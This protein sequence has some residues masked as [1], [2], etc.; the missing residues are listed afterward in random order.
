MRR[1]KILTVTL[2]IILIQQNNAVS[3]SALTIKNVSVINELGHV[4]ISWEYVGSDTLT[5][6]KY[7]RAALS[8]VEFHSITDPS[9]TSYIDTEANAHIEPQSYRIGDGVDITDDVATFLLTFDYDSCLQQIDLTWEDLKVDQYT[10]NDW[11]PSEFIINIYEDGNLRMETVDIENQ[12][13]SI[14]NVLE[15]T[16]Y[17]IFVETKW[18]GQD[19]TS[20]SNP[21]SK[22]TEMPESPEYINAVYATANGNSVDLKFNIAPNSEL[23]TYKLLKSSTPNGNYDTLEVFNTISTEIAATDDNANAESTINYYKLVSLNQCNNERTN[24]DVINNI[25]LTADNNNFDNILSWN[26]FMEE[27]LISVDYELYRITENS[28][29]QLIASFANHNSYTDNI[30]S[31]QNYSQFCYYVKAIKESDTEASFSQSNSACIYLDPKIYIPEAFTP[32]GNGRNDCFK[33]CGNFEVNSF[34]L[35][36]FDRWGTPVFE[37]NTFSP[38]ADCEECEEGAWN[39]KYTNGKAVPAGAYIYVLEINLT[40]GQVINKTGNITVIYP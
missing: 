32:D 25:V 19:S 37:T 13:H 4:R 39:G 17:E 34:H 11:T 14:Q 3:Q 12:T 7:N 23:E 2:L 24:S 31:L 10:A 18:V 9:I 22:F 30:E 16:A 27:S 21:I 36:I 29:P 26:I 5:L 6:F 28:Q 38:Y 1:I 8:V 40:N 20:Y 15:N 35:K 33:V